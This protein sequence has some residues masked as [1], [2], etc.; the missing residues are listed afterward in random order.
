LRS[1]ALLLLL[2]ATLAT[3]AQAR[4]TVRPTETHPVLLSITVVN[5]PF[6]SVLTALRP[7]LDRPADLAIQRDPLVTWQGR[8][9]APA[10]ALAALTR[11]A[12]LSLSAGGARFLIGDRKENRQVGVVTLD[13]KDEDVRT[14]LKSIQVQCGIPN[15]VLDKDVQGTG[16]FLFHDLPCR[17]ALAVVL[18]STGLALTDD[19]NSVTGVGR[20]H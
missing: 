15:L 1:T 9:I 19:S 8:R 3:P 7:Y 18:S 4:V 10:D 13:V 5:E 11:H 2:C 12:G 14:I 16:T 6:S 20:Q 17:R